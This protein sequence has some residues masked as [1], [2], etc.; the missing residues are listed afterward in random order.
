M[1]LDLSWPEVDV[2]ALR[3][4]VSEGLST[5]QTAKRMGRTKNSCASKAIRLGIKFTGGPGGPAK[6]NKPKPAPKPVSVPVA[7]VILVTQEPAEPPPPSEGYTL[8]DLPAKGCRWPLEGSTPEIM[9]CGA[10][11]LPKDPYCRAHRARAS[12]PF[13]TSA[14]KLARGLRKW[15]S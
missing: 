12:T 7:M 11:A 10:T 14:A 2:L 3:Q 15:T 13:A 6:T 8:T 9:M 1:S 5:A 4:A